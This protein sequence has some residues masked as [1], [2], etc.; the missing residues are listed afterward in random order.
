MSDREDQDEFETSE[1]GLGPE[2]A[3]QS[4]DLQDLDSDEVTDLL[5]EGQSFEAGILSGIENAS[6][7]DGGIR[8]REVPEDDVPQ[9]Y[10]DQERDDQQ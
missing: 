8:T 6:T 2:S 10:I 9:E 5:E 4:G 3:G 1:T 7:D